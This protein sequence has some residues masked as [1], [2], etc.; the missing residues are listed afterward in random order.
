MKLNSDLISHEDFHKGYWLN[1]HGCDWFFFYKS[2]REFNI[3][4]NKSFYNTLDEDLKDLVYF[5]HS[6]GIPTTPS[7]SGHIQNDN[8]YNDI[9]TSLLK[10]TQKIKKTG[11]NLMNAESNKKFYYRNPKFNLPYSRNEFIDQLR[12]YQKKGVLGFIDQNNIYEKM[13]K[14]I[15]VLN[16]DGVTLILTEGKN[17]N[18][19]KK[20][21]KFINQLI[22]K[23]ID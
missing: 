13:K 14:E 15:D 9:F 22:K 21:W 17:E 6:K 7:C 16:N 20:N 19:I 12:D 4:R 8:H 5:F 23:L 2:P 1:T 10:T 18:E 11:V 3:P